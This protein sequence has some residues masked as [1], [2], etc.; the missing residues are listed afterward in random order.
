M[1]I[2]DFKIGQK[3]FRVSSS[4]YSRSEYEEVTKVGRKWV[5]VGSNGQ[6]RFDPED[7]LEDGGQYCSSATY[8]LSEEAYT[9]HQA[10]LSY[11]GKFKNIISSYY[12]PDC[13]IEQLKEAAKLLGI[14]ESIEENKQSD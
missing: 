2:K 9:I 13:D 6:M 11:W 12:T 5:T 3:V 7:M 14:F 4:R 1:N 8:Y 10:R